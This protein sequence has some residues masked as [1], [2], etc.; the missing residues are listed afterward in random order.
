MAGRTSERSKLAALAIWAVVAAC[1][2]VGKETL[3][4]SSTSSALEKTLSNPLLISGAGGVAHSA[5]SANPA[6]T[7]DASH[8]QFVYG[9]TSEEP[10]RKRPRPTKTGGPPDERAQE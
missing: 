10:G 7:F 3:R 6:L 1:H 8:G 4:S 9:G 5:P 2:D